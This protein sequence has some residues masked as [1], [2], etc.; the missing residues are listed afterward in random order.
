MAAGLTGFAYR[1]VIRRERLKSDLKIRQVEADKLWE[2]N[3]AKSRFFSNISHE[4][5]TPLTLIQGSAAILRE[6][7]K[8]ETPARRGT[9]TCSKE[10]PGGFCNSSASYSICRASKQVN[11]PCNP[12]PATS[13]ISCGPSCTHLPRWPNGK[14]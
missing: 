13:R 12:S 1:S 2:L 14:G 7:E 5:R 11:S 10:T 9:T 8:K 4:L 3:Q 6:G